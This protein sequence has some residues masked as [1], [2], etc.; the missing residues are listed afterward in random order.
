MGRPKKEKTLPP[1]QSAQSSDDYS[2]PVTA[3][4]KLNNP[5]LLECGSL[6]SNIAYLVG[7]WGFRPGYAEQYVL[8]R[9]GTKKS[10]SDPVESWDK[11][12]E[13]ELDASI[14]SIGKSNDFS[15]Q[16]TARQLGI[17]NDKV[18]QCFV[19]NGCDLVSRRA[20]K[21]EEKKRQAIHMKMHGFSVKTIATTLKTSN[22]QIVEWLRQLEKEEGAVRI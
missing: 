12:D 4:E 18:K 11:E 13:L 6:N 7:V 16:R 3:V 21:R 1:A 17:K 20:K 9:T 22:G 19:R 5:T 8:A 2:R 15:I 14:L 10:E